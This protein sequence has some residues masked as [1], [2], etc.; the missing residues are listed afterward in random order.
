MP[1]IFKNLTLEEILKALHNVEE[2]EEENRRAEVM[3]EQLNIGI[4]EGHRGSVFLENVENQSQE[5]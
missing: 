2:K 3:K 4:L 5:I 1:G